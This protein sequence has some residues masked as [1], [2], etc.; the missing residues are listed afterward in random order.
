MPQRRVEEGHGLRP[1]HQN[2]D[3]LLDRGLG[4]SAENCIIIVT[5]RLWNDGKHEAWRPDT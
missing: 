5:D 2:S 3:A 1:L 4:F